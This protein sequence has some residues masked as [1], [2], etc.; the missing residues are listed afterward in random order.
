MLHTTSYMVIYLTI[1]VQYSV[2]REHWA[3][4]YSPIFFFI[5]YTQH[6]TY[7]NF[8]NRNIRVQLHQVTLE[9]LLKHISE[10][11]ANNQIV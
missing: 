3:F 4:L 11:P 10:I 8:L 9:N 7:Y 1:G 2:Y 6:L 5:N